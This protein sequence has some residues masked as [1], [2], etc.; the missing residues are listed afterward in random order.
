M[1]P[2]LLRSL[3]SLSD[4]YTHLSLL[5]TLALNNLALLTALDLG[6]FS[7]HIADVNLRS[8]DLG[9]QISNLVLDLLPQTL[10][11]GNKFLSLLVGGIEGTLARFVLLAVLLANLVTLVL[12]LHTTNTSPFFATIAAEVVV[13]E[14]IVDTGEGDVAGLM[15]L[16]LAVESRKSEGGIQ[17]AFF[18]HIG[19]SGEGEWGEVGASGGSRLIGAVGAVTIVVIDL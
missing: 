16:V 12:A 13:A 4:E 8:L 3:F 1:I 5:G 11:L 7:F 18:R 6:H 14:A 9:L 17:V 10:G 2:K 15:T 19:Q